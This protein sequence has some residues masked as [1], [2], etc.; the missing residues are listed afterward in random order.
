M[1]PWRVGDYC[2]QGWRTREKE[3]KILTMLLTELFMLNFL[4]KKLR[5][6][7]LSFVRQ[8]KADA[9]VEGNKANK[10]SRWIIESHT[11]SI[12]RG[13]KKK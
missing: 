7:M 1:D 13:E 9:R 8:T 11:G 6:N 3:S 2:G 10:C 5:I 4:M 12:N